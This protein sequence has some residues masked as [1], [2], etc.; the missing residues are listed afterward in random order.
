MSG[1]QSARSAV[2]TDLDKAFAA[3]LADYEMNH[4]P[5]TAETV[6]DYVRAHF[7][8]F[9]RSFDRFTPL[10]Y[11]EYMRQRIQ[12]V[13]RASLRKELSAL[14]QFR[15][16]CEEQGVTGLAPIP[17]LPK[18]GHP[19][20]RAKNA[21]RRM[22]TILSPAEIAR[23]LLAMPERS[24]RT[25]AFVR[26]FFDVLWE[27]G[28]RP[29]STVLK[30]EAPLHYKRGGSTLFISREIDK[31]RYEREIPITAEAQA[32][33]ER[34]CPKSGTG[35]LFEV[36]TP[37]NMEDSLAAAVAAAGIDKPISIYDFRH[38]R[39]SYLANSGAPLA[40]VARLVGHKHVSTTALY[41]QANNA[42]A[43]AALDMVAK[44]V[45]KGGTRRGTR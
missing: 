21:R 8:P 31:A 4:T 36:D 7:V 38:S 34:V 24:R 42:A 12:K 35:K 39:I 13:T 44:P 9:F 1:R 14:R 33:L 17:S 25:G 23:I 19:G 3:W 6:T 16:W 15:A 10:S 22:A 43:Q 28:L 26:P 30:L 45:G 18:A 41:V 20:K 32:A 37:E 27:T 2:S 5:G 40:G 11:G 29:Y